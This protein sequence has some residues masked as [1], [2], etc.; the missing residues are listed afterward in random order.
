MNQSQ[1]Q[2]EGKPRLELVPA[3]TETR[4]AMVMAQALEKYTVNSWLDVEP[5]R[6]IG[7]LMRH[8]EAYREGENID[9]DSGLPHIDHVMTN[10][11]FLSY[12]WG[13]QGDSTSP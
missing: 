12:F 4:I 7:A 8:L 10:A 11:V 2:D 3:G 5:R 6:F 1:K 9:P 13:S